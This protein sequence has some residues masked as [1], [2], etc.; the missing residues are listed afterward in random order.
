MRLVLCLHRRRSVHLVLIRNASGLIVCSIPDLSGLACL[1]VSLPQ[2]QALSLFLGLN[3]I[4]FLMPFFFKF[5]SLLLS[6]TQGTHIQNPQKWR[7][8]HSS[9]KEL[10]HGCRFNQWNTKGET[11]APFS[12]SLWN[13]LKIFWLNAASMEKCCMPRSQLCYFTNCEPPAFL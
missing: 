4:L 8:S 3:A 12:S 1:S 9:M 13:Y 11:Y 2:N 10:P 6:H 5:L 7:D